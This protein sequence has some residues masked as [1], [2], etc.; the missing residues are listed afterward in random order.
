[1]AMAMAVLLTL[2][3]A[4]ALKPSSVLGGILLGA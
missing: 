1:M 3:L 4:L 2:T